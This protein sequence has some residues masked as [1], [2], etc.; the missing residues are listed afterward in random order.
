MYMPS[1]IKSASEGSVSLQMEKLDAELLQCSGGAVSL[2]VVIHR[3]Q[4]IHNDKI[5]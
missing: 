3:T 4:L 2:D 5:P 1:L